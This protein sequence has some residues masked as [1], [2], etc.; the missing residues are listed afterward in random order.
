LPTQCPLR[1]AHLLVFPMPY[2]GRQNW[3]L[4]DEGGDLRLAPFGESKA[5][6]D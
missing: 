6:R 2:K 5:R 1:T 4:P 3:L